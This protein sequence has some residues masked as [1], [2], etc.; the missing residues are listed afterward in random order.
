MIRGD[1]YRVRIIRRSLTPPR[2]EKKYRQ[3]STSGASLP[4][5]SLGPIEH[6]TKPVSKPLVQADFR[7]KFKRRN[8]D[9]SFFTQFWA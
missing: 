2:I 7:L 6:N 3:E 4:A 1:R 9:F 5:L 8:L